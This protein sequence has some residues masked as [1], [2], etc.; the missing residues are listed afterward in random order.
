MPD[1]QKDRSS[2]DS[3]ERGAVI[4]GE[5][6]EK[7][8]YRFLYIIVCPISIDIIVFL[9]CK[10]ITRLLAMNELPASENKQ[11]TQFYTP[12]ELM[13][14]FRDM[15]SDQNTNKKVIWMRGVYLINNNNKFYNYDILRDELTGEEITL[16]VSNELKQKVTNGNLVMVAGIVLREIKKG[17]YVQLQLKATRIE[18][19]QEQTISE[20]E[21]KLAELRN[22]KLKKGFHNVDTLLEN[23]LYTE[24]RP[25][26]ALIFADTSI[27]DKDFIAGKAAASSHIDFSEFRVSFNK[28][29][30]FLQLLKKLDTQSFDAISIIRGGGTGLEVVDNINLI[31][32]IVYMSTPIISAIGHENDKIFIKNIAD[33]VVAVPHALGTYFKDMVERVISE[34]SKSRAALVEQVKKQY[35]KQLV[36]QE[37]QNKSLQKQLKEITESHKLASE[38]SNTQITNLQKQLKEIFET[39][40]AKDKRNLEQITA[41]TVQIKKLTDNQIE[42]D[43]TATK[44]TEEL[45]KQLIA[46]QIKIDNLLKSI[47]EKN[48]QINQLSRKRPGCLGMAATFAGIII[49]ILFII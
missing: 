49:F 31:E 11:L 43:R 5:T 47:E 28:T 42:Q 30:D 37:E 21:I 41:F 4:K 8:Y 38:K 45:N 16:M 32:T 24:D 35:E 7:F 20:T 25:K 34:K 29:S 10:E 27:T 46:S 33:K 39:N 26:I 48:L 1:E 44:R 40:T 2:D 19:I 6:E 36:Q 14:I 13:S 23:K 22:I 12:T 18:I 3:T 15:L 9:F 17:G